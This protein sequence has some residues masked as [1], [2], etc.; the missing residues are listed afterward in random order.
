MAHC[1]SPTK[2]LKNGHFPSNQIQI[3][4]D[5]NCCKLF[6]DNRLPAGTNFSPDTSAAKYWRPRREDYRRCLSLYRG[7][8]GG[9]L[10]AIRFRVVPGGAEGNGGANWHLRLTET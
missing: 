9:Q 8:A 10:P 7:G 5:S 6:M 4:P 1:L 3:V 2:G